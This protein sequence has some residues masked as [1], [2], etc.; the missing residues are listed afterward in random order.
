VPATAPLAKKTSEALGF[1]NEKIL[2]TKLE[3]LSDQDCY[4]DVGVDL[5]LDDAV[6]LPS[7]DA[8][9]LNIDYKLE[10]SIQQAFDMP[11]HS[12]L[13]SSMPVHDDASPWSTRPSA[14]PRE[15]SED[16]LPSAEWI[17]RGGDLLAAH[18]FKGYLCSPP[19]KSSI[20]GIGNFTNI[21]VHT[22]EA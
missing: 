4:A 18:C 8:Q 6:L 15:L 5:V 17:D 9:D 22:L 16:C 13:N 12:K 21:P 1:Q 7:I 20:D 11:M 10:K 19:W 3:V 2:K 14:A